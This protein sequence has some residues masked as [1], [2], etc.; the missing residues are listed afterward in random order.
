MN[1][2]K[3]ILDGILVL[4]YQ[5]GDKKALA[6]LVKRY[7]NDFCRYACWYTGDIEMARDVVQ[8]SW[9][10]VFLKLKRLRNPDS[11]KSWA[12]RIIT[13]KAQDQLKASGRVREFKTQYQPP[14][15]T[16]ESEDEVRLANLRMIQAEIEKM[17]FNHRLVLRL[18]YTE[19]HSLK[20][21]SN[22]LGISTGTVKSR[23]YHAREK[24]KSELKL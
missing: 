20:E 3:K 7:H 18:F 22:I 11:F 8:D 14:Y 5:K 17:S 2:R 16:N 23:L 4:R 19:Q 1:D 6:V 21:I 13:R 10:I 15:E 24:L 9:G 12:M